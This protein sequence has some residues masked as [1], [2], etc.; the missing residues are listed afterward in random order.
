MK[1][2]DALT[3]MR[4][5]DDRILQLRTSQFD[6]LTRAINRDILFLEDLNLMDYSLLV[7]IEVLSSSALSSPFVSS[8]TQS[9]VH[10]ELKSGPVSGGRTG[11]LDM[12]AALKHHSRTDANVNTDSET[13]TNSNNNNNR[14]FKDSDCDADIRHNQISNGES[15]VFLPRYV[16]W[17]WYIL[18][19]PFTSHEV[20]SGKDH[21]TGRCVAS[22]QCSR[23]VL[24][25]SCML[26]L[27]YGCVAY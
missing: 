3:K 23:L 20:G 4:N 26:V 14:A 11:V 16:W 9:H 10:H 19:Y 2:L 24:M 5:S 1:D 6:L 25:Y 15:V 7:G 13:N 22:H 8:S 18:N 27:M 21:S 17:R 12:I